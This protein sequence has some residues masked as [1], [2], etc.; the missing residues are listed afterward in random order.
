M[1]IG[2]SDHSV[3]KKGRIFIPSRFKGDFGESIV[4]CACA[5]G[6]KCLWGFTEAGFEK[7]CD[8]LNKLPYG[9]MQDIYRFLSNSAVFA[10]LDASG[11]VLLPS[12]LRSF[13]GIESDVHIV[14][15]RSNIEIWSPENWQA[16]QGNFSPESF[17]PVIDELGFSFGE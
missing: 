2:G 10:E 16:E 14:G 7:F 5:F 12:E 15:M 8:K 17:A 9:K 13:A 3:D 6:K 11:R 4:I 1:L